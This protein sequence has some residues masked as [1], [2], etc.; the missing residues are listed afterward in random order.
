MEPLETKVVTEE[1]PPFLGGWNR[2]YTAV[3][4][5]LGL[6][7]VLLYIITRMFSA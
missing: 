1:P 2:V 3:L 4:V 6:L 7:I 5:Y